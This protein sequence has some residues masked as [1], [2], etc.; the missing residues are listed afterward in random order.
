M[1]G[2]QCIWNEVDIAMAIGEIKQTCKQATRLNDSDWS[3]YYAAVSQLTELIKRKYSQCEANPPS[4]VVRHSSLPQPCPRCHVPMSGL[5]MQCE[6]FPA[7]H[8]D[9]MSETSSE[10]WT[11]SICSAANTDSAYI[12]EVCSGHRLLREEVKKHWKCEHCGYKYNSQ[13]LQECANCHTSK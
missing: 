8:S 2:S 12:C 4:P 10:T 3:L 11:C 1:D 6:S 7:V 9:P 5:C 13:Q